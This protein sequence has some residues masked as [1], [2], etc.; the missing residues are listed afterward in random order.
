MLNTKMMSR[1]KT[2]AGYQK[3][4]I[5]AL[6][7]EGMEEHVDVIENEIRSMLMEAVTKAAQEC[8]NSNCKSDVIKEET[9]E[10]VKKVT[11]E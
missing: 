9:C 6:L 2:A 1:L 5:L 7:P 3:K 4:A 8:I 11:I 10:R